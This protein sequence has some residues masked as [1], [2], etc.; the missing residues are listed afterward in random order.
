MI[1]QWCAEFHCGRCNTENVRIN[2][3]KLKKKITPPERCTCKKCHLAHPFEELKFEFSLDCPTCGKSN[4]IDKDKI[5]LADGE[6]N[7]IDLL[8]CSSCGTAN[9]L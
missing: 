8:T 6:W 2:Q 3:I 1:G 5:I 4:E 7:I 9:D